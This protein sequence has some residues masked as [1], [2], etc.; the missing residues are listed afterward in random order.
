MVDD[1]APKIFAAVST[2]TWT[3][4][5]L[6]AAGHVCGEQHSRRLRTPYRRTTNQVAGLCRLAGDFGARR[7]SN[8]CR[9]SGQPEPDCRIPY[10]GRPAAP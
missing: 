8:R 5:G 7:E 4:A 9:L 2:A 10:A 1:T 3:D 6:A